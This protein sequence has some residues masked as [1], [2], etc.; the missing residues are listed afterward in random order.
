[1]STATPQ[2][3]PSSGSAFHEMPSSTSKPSSP[4]REDVEKYSPSTTNTAQPPDELRRALGTRHMVM[5]AIGGIIGPGLLVGSGQALASAGPVGALIAFAITGGIVYFVLQ[6]LGEMATLFAI[7][8]SFIEYAGR[9]VDPALGFVAGWVYWEL[10]VSVLSNEYNAVAIVIRYWDGAQ[11]VP[12]GAWIAIFWVLFMGLSMLGVLAYGEVEFVLA[13]IKVIGIVV[14]FILSIVI[15]VGGAGGDQGYIGFRYFK[16]P[17]PF[18]GTGIDALNGIAKILVV[19]AT[20]YAGTEATA[21]TAAESKNPAKSVPIAIRSV[22][23]RILVLYLGTIFFIGLN[24]PSDDTSLVSAQS[25]AAASPLTIA[26]R[27]GGIGAAA[28]LIN[29]LIVLSVISAGNSSLYIASRTL[30]SLGATGRAPAIL[31]WV[32]PRGKVPIP[33]LVLSNL[34]ALIS[35]LSINAGAS[36][37][38][39]Y[40]I[41][42]SGVSTF[43]IFAIICFCHIRFRQAWLK[44][45]NTL[46]ELPFRAFGAPYGTWGA[47]VLNIVLMFFQGYTTFLNPRK[48]AD[49]VVA[50]IVIPVAVALFVGWKWWHKTKLVALEDVDLVSGR[51]LIEDFEPSS[52]QEQEQGSADKLDVSEKKWYRNPKKVLSRIIA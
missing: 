6:A 35:L 8:G 11:V 27:R 13:T 41:N 19:S 14:F 17:G 37:V 26:L 49:I 21:I 43:I 34:V 48:A 42:I 30:Q 12:T 45:G 10:W 24:V 36:T 44:Q 7:R 18:N 25:K 28:S 31:G 32:T 29:A 22:F 33:A 40:I 3:D 52:R 46:E 38:F 15:N 9:W 39:T 51:R 1:M 4:S 23:Y 2:P 5:I 47:F 50:Y 20:L 16:T